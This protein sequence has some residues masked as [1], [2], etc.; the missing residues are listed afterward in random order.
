MLDAAA[1]YQ[2]IN[3]LHRRL[4]EIGVA[5]MVSW[6]KVQVNAG[7]RLTHCGTST[8]RKIRSGRR[9]PGLVGFSMA[10]NPDSGHPKGGNR[11]AAVPSSLPL[12]QARCSSKLS[13]S[14]GERL[15]ASRR[16]SPLGASKVGFSLGRRGWPD[17]Q[18]N[19]EVGGATRRIHHNGGEQIKRRGVWLSR[20][21]F[22]RMKPGSSGAA[23]P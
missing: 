18:E 12:E 17:A 14:V 2:R 6:S 9:G 8:Y 23:G 10:E 5:K 7:M 3:D 19:S 21:A 20:A 15:C 13:N 1:M 22:P 16:E 11:S 4:T